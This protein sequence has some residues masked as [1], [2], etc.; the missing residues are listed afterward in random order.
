MNLSHNCV[1]GKDNYT[2]VLLED[3]NSKFGRLIDAVS[4]MQDELKSKADKDDISALR[5]DINVIKAAVTDTNEQ[6]RDHEVRIAS[7]ESA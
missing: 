7:L 2:D 1:M 6:V 4:Q 3:V 5:S